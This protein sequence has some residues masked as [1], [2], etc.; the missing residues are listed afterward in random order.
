MAGSSEEALY[1]RFYEKDANE[2]PL[3]WDYYGELAHSNGAV[4]KRMIESGEGKCNILLYGAPGT[5]KTSFARSLAK[6][7]GRTV[8]QI[9][10]GDEEGNNMKPQTRM[11]GIQ[12]CNAQESQETSIMLVDA[13]TNPFL[14]FRF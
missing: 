13:T 10:Q 6:E 8:F 3:P 11:I 1:R 7:L 9:R 5:G 12:M 14:Y 4:L 2:E